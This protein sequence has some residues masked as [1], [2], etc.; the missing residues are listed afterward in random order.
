M[1]NGRARGQRRGK[2][3]EEEGREE[4]E[5]PKVGSHASAVSRKMWE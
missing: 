2:G 1:E 4:E 5:T 3:M